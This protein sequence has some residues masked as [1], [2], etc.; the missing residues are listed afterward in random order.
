[1]MKSHTLSLTLL[2]T[3]L[4]LA[5]TSVGCT[6]ETAQQ[7]ETDVEQSAASALTGTCTASLGNGLLGGFGRLD[8]TVFALV[9]PRTKG[10]P[11]DSSHLHVQIQSQGSVYDAAVNLDGLSTTV[12]AP[13]A[14]GPWSDGW[15]RSVSL[16]YARDLK[17]HSANF[18]PTSL[19][20]LE[21]ALTVGK[22]ISMFMTPFSHSGGHLVHRGRTGGHDGAMV[23][24][25]DTN[26]PKYVLFTFSQ[27]AF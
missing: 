4:A 2:A 19:K 27:L 16:D 5:A 25:A 8:G 11:S 22:H 12:S 3:C 14:A 9:E 17:V 18:S 23:I 1:M 15:H 6:A 26:A 21:S 20:T 7:G 10:C 24:D 13:L